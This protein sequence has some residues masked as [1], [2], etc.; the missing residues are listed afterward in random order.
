MTM[1]KRG[2]DAEALTRIAGNIRGLQGELARIEQSSRSA[3]GSIQG[4]WGGQNLLTLVGHFNDT[5]IPAMRAC[6]GV[7]DAMAQKLD[8]NAKAQVATSGGGAGGTAGPGGAGGGSGGGGTSTGG[9]PSVPPPHG[10]NDV[11]KTKGK[12]FSLEDKD[13]DETS[14]GEGNQYTRTQHGSTQTYEN[15]R[16]GA[17]GREHYDRYTHAGD[18]HQPQLQHET[19]YT[20]ETERDVHRPWLPTDGSDDPGRFANRHD[21]AS[22]RIGHGVEAVN[23]TYK[24]EHPD[25]SYTTHYYDS[26]GNPTDKDHAASSTMGGT[27]GTETKHHTEVGIKDGALYAGAGAG[28]GA[29]LLKGKVDGNLGD[30]GRYEAGGFVGAEAKADAGVS[31]GKDGLQAKVNAEAFA[32][33]K[34]NVGVS[35]DNGPLAGH[36]DANVM[37]GA[38]AK[39]DASVGIGKDGVKAH[40]GA[41][42]FAGVKAGAEV[43]GNVAGVGGTVGGEV[44]AG[45]GAHADID[46]NFSAESVKVK[47]DVGAAIGIGGGVKFSVDVQPKEMMSDVGHGLGDAGKAIDGGL[48]H[49]AKAIGKV[50]G[51]H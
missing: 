45:I 43:G 32:G 18:Y 6:N 11:T 10:K 38:E 27:L 29:Y 15:T 25:S 4:N 3:M 36:A 16:T 50:F 46:A 12:K 17:D 23:W 44:Y 1:Y 7:F 21:D 35:Y 2:A 14:G 9:G 33:A 31:L 48:E 39:A 19:G 5:A 34:G 40:A 28:A 49:G 41:D 42:A 20:R 26:N 24:D 8:T 13:P 30:H 47:V 37:A 51:W 22:R